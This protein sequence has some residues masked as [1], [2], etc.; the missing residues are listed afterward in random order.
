MNTSRRREFL[1]D[2]G[3]GM[4]IASVGPGLALDLGL[5]PALADE[6]PQPLSLLHET[7]ASGRVTRRASSDPAC[8]LRLFLLATAFGE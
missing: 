7:T 3:R 2:V 5:S 4:L 8:L 1:A 6:P